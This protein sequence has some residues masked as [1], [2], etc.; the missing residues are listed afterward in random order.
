MASGVVRQ[1]V[2]SFVV[3]MGEVMDYRG[4]EER[5]MVVEVKVKHLKEAI[6]LHNQLVKE[7]FRVQN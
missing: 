2:L 1:Q 5:L 6:I 7:K 4:L 3:H